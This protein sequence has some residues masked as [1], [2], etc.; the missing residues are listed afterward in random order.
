MPSQT[1]DELNHH[2]GIDEHIAFHQGSGDFPFVTLTTSHGTAEVCLYGAHLTSWIPTGA[3]EVIWTSPDAIYLTG[4]AIRGGIPVCWPR[5]ADQDTP[6][7]IPAHGVARTSLWK[8]TSTSADDTEAKITLRLPP[9]E[10]LPAFDLQLAITVSKEL[11]LE[12][13]TTN[14]SDQPFTI[15]QALHTYLNV[16]DIDQVEISG[17]DEVR[18]HDKMDDYQEKIQTG[19]LTFDKA[20]DSI[21]E[22]T[23]S[24]V[25][26][27]DKSLARTIKVTKA[28]SDTT[29]IWNP[30]KETAEKMAD[31]PDN[32][33][34]TMVC[35]EAA[36]AGEEIITL[37]AGKSHTLTTTI[38]SIP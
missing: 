1:P 9:C 29:V 33:Y 38:A 31:M 2:F 13:T 27:H 19:N 37:N 35:I 5:F 11:H 18:Y 16:G 4:K 3:A 7:D 25:L 26:L 21:Y 6:Y 17:L 10:N 8:V 28:G 34:Q 36:N 15:T 23:S 14:L 22:G 12:L 24:D 32:G 30:W 20:F